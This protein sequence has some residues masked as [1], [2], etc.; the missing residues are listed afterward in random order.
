MMSYIVRKVVKRGAITLIGK[1]AFG[2]PKLAPAPARRV[3]LWTRMARA[4]LQVRAAMLLT[5]PATRVS[6]VRQHL[7]AI[8]YVMDI[9]GL[10]LVGM[11]ETR[12]IVPARAVETMMVAA[13]RVVKR[14]RLVKLYFAKTTYLR[15]VILLVS[16]AKMVGKRVL[17]TK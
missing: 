13:R 3:L 1:R 12:W 6:V 14:E 9:I 17:L 7:L 11:L 16:M 15:F 4:L 5:R 8:Q 2:V 10:Q